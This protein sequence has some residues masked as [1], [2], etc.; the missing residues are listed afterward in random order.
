MDCPELASICRVHL[1]KTS[2]GFRLPRACKYLPCPSKKD[3]SW[4]QTAQSLQV[5]ASVHLNKDE[6]WLQT[7]IYVPLAALKADWP[8]ADLASA[9]GNA[10]GK[11]REAFVP[12]A[13]CLFQR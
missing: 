10:D 9:A 8:P 5:S 12:Y 13:S 2:R 11:Q 1:K 4:L 7:A 6:S 3:E